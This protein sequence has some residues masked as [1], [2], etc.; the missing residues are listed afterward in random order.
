MLID[1]LSHIQSLTRKIGDSIKS[2]N[3]MLR[4]TVNIDRQTLK[5]CEKHLKEHNNNILKLLRKIV[6]GLTC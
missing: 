3:N 6:D 4:L 5:T 1:A 2:V